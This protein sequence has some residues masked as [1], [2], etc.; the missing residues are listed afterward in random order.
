MVRVRGLTKGFGLGFGTGISTGPFHSRD[1]PI[2]DAAYTEWDWQRAWWVNSELSGEYRWASGFELRG[3]VGAGYL[4]NGKPDACG[5][6]D[7]EAG[8][9]A[10]PCGEPLAHNPSSGSV[11]PYMGL[12]IG[13]SFGSS[14]RL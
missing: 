13:Y 10:T 12:A 11:L 8:Q 2:L 7:P 9:R 6:Y 14:W 5:Q 1:P 4:V 3:F